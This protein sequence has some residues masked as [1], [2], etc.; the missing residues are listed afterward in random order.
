MLAHTRGMWLYVF[1]HF[2]SSEWP[3][4]STSCAELMSSWAFYHHLRLSD[5]AGALLRHE[6]LGIRNPFWLCQSSRLFF[7]PQ[8][9]FIWQRYSACAFFVGVSSSSFRRWPNHDN[10]LLFTV[11]LYFSIPVFSYSSLLIIIFGH[12]T[13]MI[14]WSSF[15]WKKSILSSMILVV[16]HI[17]CCI[18]KYS[19]R[20]LRKNSILL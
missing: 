3:L 8:F 12:L 11:L 16:V 1:S 20:K 5:I 13:L 17:C 6:Y 14:W 4:Y 2:P 15:G 19:G 10:L 18:V 7:F 9:F